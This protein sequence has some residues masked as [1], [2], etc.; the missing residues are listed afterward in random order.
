[1]PPGFDEDDLAAIDTIV[2]PQSRKIY[3]PPDKQKIHWSTV[4]FLI[5]NRTIGSGIFVSSA[6]VL[7]NTR[8]PGVSLIFWAI[9]GLLTLCAVLVWLEFG[10]STPVK[11]VA[12][13]IVQ[14]V[15]R[16]GGEKN[17]VSSITQ[18]LS[19]LTISSSNTPL[20]DQSSLQRAC[21]E[22]HSSY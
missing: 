17:Y 22:S 4:G 12:G 2:D 14:C 3:T 6:S 9:G 19:F 15:P 5:L 10:L 13:G 21:S 18:T 8:S 20:N 11:R 1:M 7:Q 16:S